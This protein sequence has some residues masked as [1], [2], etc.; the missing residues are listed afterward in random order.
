MNPAQ[1]AYYARSQLQRVK[2][3]KVDAKLIAE[4][5][6]RHQDE[7]RAW[8]PEPRAIR[9]LRALVRRLEDLQEIEQ[10]ERNRLEVADTSVQDSIESVL[11]H[12]DQQID[13]TLRAIKQ[14][15]DDDP[16]LRGKHDL[17]TSIDGIGD[18]TAALLLAELADPLRFAST[19]P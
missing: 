7:L 1:V 12:V 5:G 14:H 10:M 6:E 13:E 16:D 11:Q 17:L 3:D 2:T 8:Q 9:R 15:I 18:K 19:V 4:Y